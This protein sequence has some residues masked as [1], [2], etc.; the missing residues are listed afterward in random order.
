MKYSKKLTMKLILKW[1]S[2]RFKK[3]TKEVYDKTNVI[4]KDTYDSIIIDKNKK[5][6]KIKKGKKNIEE[7][8]GIYKE[9]SLEVN[10]KIDKETTEHVKLNSNENV[11]EKKTKKKEKK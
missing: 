6:R 9:I 10:N 8:D 11:N 3:L 2:K 5:K 4:S 1:I 7:S